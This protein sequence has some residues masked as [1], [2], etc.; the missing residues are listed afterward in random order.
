[1]SVDASLEGIGAPLSSDLTDLKGDASSDLK[2][3]FLGDIIDDLNL[4]TTAV[5][6]GLF[7]MPCRS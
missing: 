5:F 1:M 7:M 6:K 4:S 3:L 2:Q